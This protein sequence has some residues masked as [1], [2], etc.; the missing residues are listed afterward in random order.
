M[1]DYLVPIA[2][3]HEVP[4]F[5]GIITNRLD[6]SGFLSKDDVVTLAKNPLI[7]I[8]SHSISHTDNSKLSE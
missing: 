3:K 2:S 8:A 1:R 7:S 6:K 5:L 4:F